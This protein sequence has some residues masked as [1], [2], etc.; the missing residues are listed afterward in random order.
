MPVAGTAANIF[1]LSIIVANQVLTPVL[2]VHDELVF[3]V[4]ENEVDKW[5]QP[6]CAAMQSIDFPLALKVDASVGNHLGELI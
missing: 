5:T 3:E 1:K 4:P 2:N 6:L